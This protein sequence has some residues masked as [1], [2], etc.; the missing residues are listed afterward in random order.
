MTTRR[1]FTL[2]LLLPFIIAG[3][4]N[5]TVTVQESDLVF[6]GLPTYQYSLTYTDLLTTNKF[7]QDFQVENMGVETGSTRF[8]HAIEGETSAV[9]TI[10]WDFS[11]TGFLPTNVVFKD[12]FSLFGYNDG[13]RNQGTSSFSVDGSDWTAVTGPQ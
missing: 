3:R 9:A 2:C 11:E 1:V 6:N 5:A 10:I 4:T 12:S 13:A 7:F 8:I